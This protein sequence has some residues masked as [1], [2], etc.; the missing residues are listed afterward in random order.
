MPLFVA[1][2]LCINEQKFVL[3]VIVV[4][5]CSATVKKRLAAYLR[6]RIVHEFLLYKLQ[7]HKFRHVHVEKCFKL[8]Y[9]KL[10]FHL[11]RKSDFFC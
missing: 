1:W 2:N 8:T 6:V 9:N 4:A 5:L 10:S 3:G 11:Y 7:M